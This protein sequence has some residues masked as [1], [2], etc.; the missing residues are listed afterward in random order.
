VVLDVPR[1][2]FQFL[3]P[4][5]SVV[6]LRLGL[7]AYLGFGVELAEIIFFDVDTFGDTF[8]DDVHERERR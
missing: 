3:K 7:D 5:L 4:F 6:R 2:E 8:G 1:N